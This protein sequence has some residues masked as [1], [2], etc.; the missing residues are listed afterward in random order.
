MLVFDRVAVRRHRDRA[1][2]TV[3]QVADVL[4]DAAERLLDRWTIRRGGS[5]ALD[6]GGRGVVAP[7]LRERGI[8]VVSSDLSPEMAAEWRVAGCR[9]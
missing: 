9:G 3:D 8:A 2:A 6:V 1:A 4:R 5:R 7:L